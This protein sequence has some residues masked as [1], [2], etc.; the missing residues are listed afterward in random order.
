MEI[1]LEYLSPEN[2][3]RPKGWTVVGRVGTLAL[4]FD[5]AR[6][7]FLIGDGEPHPLDAA[8]VNQALVAAVDRAGMTVWP[9]GWTHALPAAFGLNKRTTQR[10]RIERQGLHPAVLQALG[11]A[12]SSSD[13]D[14]IGVL[15][16]ALASYADRHGDGGTDPRRALDDAERAA[17]NALDIL[18]GVRRGKTLLNREG[19]G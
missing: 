2:W 9:G 4:A 6:Q 14:G 11:S 3:P 1:V 18:R 16:V 8:E 19:H 12:A 15:L 10:D 13:A 7:P 5:P 17:A